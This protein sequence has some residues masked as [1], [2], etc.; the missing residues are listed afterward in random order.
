QYDIRDAWWRNESG[1]LT[2]FVGNQIVVWGQSLSF[3][4]GD[5]V[6]PTDTTWAF[7]FANLEQSR[8]PQWMIH[9]I[10]HLPDFGGFSSNFLEAVWLRGFAPMWTHNDFPDGRYYGEG[11]KEGRVQSGQPAVSH[12]PSTRF[13]IHHDGQFRSG[14][15]I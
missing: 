9:P 7:G 1:P 2:L 6:N 3:R 4:V 11:W 8:K 5:V 13:D 14:L 12:L 15:N 10:L